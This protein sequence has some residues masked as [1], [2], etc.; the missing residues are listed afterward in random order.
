[1]TNDESLSQSWINPPKRP[2]IP[3]PS[4]QNVQQSRRPNIKSK[5]GG[6]YGND[7]FLNNFNNNNNNHQHTESFYEVEQHPYTENRNFLQNITQRY[8]S[9][10]VE[11][12]KHT[13]DINSGR[14]FLSNG[15]NNFNTNFGYNTNRNINNNNNNNVESI[16]SPLDPNITMKKKA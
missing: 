14:G 6:S 13:F 9:Q 10:V 3:P 15:E 2:N 12:N 8:D 4:Q 7:G 1:M 16:V 11:F 5:Y